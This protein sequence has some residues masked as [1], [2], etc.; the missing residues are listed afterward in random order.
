MTWLLW[1]AARYRRCVSCPHGGDVGKDSRCAGLTARSAAALVFAA[2]PG[3]TGVVWWVEGGQAF[4]VT[5]TDLA[6]DLQPLAGLHTVSCLYIQRL[7]WVDHL[8]HLVQDRHVLEPLTEIMW[9]HCV[10]HIRSSLFHFLGFYQLQVF[11]L[12]RYRWWKNN[13][14]IETQNI[15][16]HCGS[17]NAPETTSTTV[18]SFVFVSQGN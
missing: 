18:S 16:F 14:Q 8:K 13:F 10:F 12:F 3:S 6:Q 1:M 15:S 5:P 2:L 4:Y 17:T 9:D 11:K 7:L